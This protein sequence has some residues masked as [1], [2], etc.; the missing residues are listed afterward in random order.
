MRM[1]EINKLAETVNAQVMPCDVS[2]NDDMLKLITKAKEQ[3]GGID[4]ILH[5]TM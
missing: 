2:S 5:S 3:F 1:G 4:F